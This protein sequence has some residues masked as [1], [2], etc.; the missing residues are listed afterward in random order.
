[1]G[2]DVPPLA[3]GYYQLAAGRL[4]K[5]GD[6]GWQVRWRRRLVGAEGGRHEIRLTAASWSSRL[7][8]MSGPSRPVPSWLTSIDSTYRMAWILLL[9]SLMC[10]TIGGSVTG[11]YY[12]FAFY[13]LAILLRPHA[14]PPSRTPRTPFPLP[15]S[16][17]PP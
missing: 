14:S 7:I 15:L 9:A 12:P 17:P 2:W 6:V 1:M 10:P 5:R 13:I 3:G 8:A 11:G 4:L 16:S